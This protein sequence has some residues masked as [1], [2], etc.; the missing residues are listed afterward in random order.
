MTEGEYVGA[1]VYGDYSCSVGCSGGGTYSSE[2][3]GDAGAG[4]KVP[5]YVETGC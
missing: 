4:A 2:A 1:L 3:G 5:Y